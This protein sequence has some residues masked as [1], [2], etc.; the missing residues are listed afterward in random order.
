MSIES[1]RDLEGL[2]R[3]G[4]V[5][6]VIL[7][8]LRTLIRPGISTAEI[9]AACARLLARHGARSGPRLDYNFPGSLCVSVNDEAVHGV[10]SP[11]RIAAG[12][13]VKLDLVAERDGYYADAALS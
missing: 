2:R 11:R 12:D 6:A 8:E 1:Q 13:L 3:V 5:V 9:D 7:A 10:P 4:R